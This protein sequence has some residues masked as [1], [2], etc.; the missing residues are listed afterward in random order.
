MKACISCGEVK[1]LDEFY[2]HPQMGDRHLNKCKACVRE[3]TRARSV[4][5]PE[6]VMRS[7]INVCANK[8]TKKNAYKAVEAAIAAKALI[9]PSV[10][11]RCVGSV[12]GDRIKRIEAHHIDYSEPLAVKWVCTRCHRKEHYPTETSANE[13]GAK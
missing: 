1:A 11:S 13:R 3:Y 8:P 2:A 12:D 5:A 7:R 6:K 9:R 4:E 10:C